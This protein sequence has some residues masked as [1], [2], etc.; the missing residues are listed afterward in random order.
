MN[1]VKDSVGSGCSWS[2][3]GKVKVT[4]EKKTGDT[5]VKTGGSESPSRL[6]WFISG[7]TLNSEKR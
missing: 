7:V 1:N 3:I 5:E 4:S 6:N 2:L